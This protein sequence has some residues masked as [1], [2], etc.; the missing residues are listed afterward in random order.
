MGRNKSEPNKSSIPKKDRCDNFD[1][2]WR[3]TY[4][5]VLKY[6][7]HIEEEEITDIEQLRPYATD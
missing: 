2:I 1:E 7:D 4:Y 3:K 5:E 6:W